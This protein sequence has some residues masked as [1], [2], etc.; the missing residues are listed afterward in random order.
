MNVNLS[1]DLR[2]YVDAKVASGQYESADEVFEAALLE[3]RNIETGELDARWLNAKL[4]V[5]LA[6]ADAGKTLPVKE[7]MAEIRRMAEAMSTRAKA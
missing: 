1:E 3:L 6:A 5:G 4:K 7:A 2:A